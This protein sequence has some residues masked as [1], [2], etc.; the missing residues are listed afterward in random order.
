MRDKQKQLNGYFTLEASFLVPVAFFLFA[1]V[2]HLSFLMSGRAYLTEDAYA[3]AFRASM[4]G[5]DEDAE[6]F[7]ASV[8]AEQTKHKY[9]GNGT[10]ALSTRVQGH[11][12]IVELKTGTNRRAFDLANA[13]PWESVSGARAIRIDVTKRIRRID[14][15]ADIA[16][17]LL[18]KSRE[19]N[20]GEE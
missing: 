10:P 3:L 14:R 6:A 2:I 20:A 16:A 15:I 5:E 17:S 19:A 7:I 1:F 11:D 12:V 8:F 4:L 13:S 18:Q 9:F